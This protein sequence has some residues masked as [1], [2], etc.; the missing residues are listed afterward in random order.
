MIDR[1]AKLGRSLLHRMRCK[2]THQFTYD[3]DGAR[4][5][6]GSPTGSRTCKTP[7]LQLKGCSQCGK[8]TIKDYRA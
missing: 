6:Y 5:E 4:R 8:L 3:L 7:G 2:H 1:I